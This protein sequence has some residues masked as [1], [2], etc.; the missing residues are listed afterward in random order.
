MAYYSKTDDM[1]LMIL[2]DDD[3]QNPRKDWDN[4]G[5][6]ICF[7]KRYNLGDEH[8]F[9]EPYKFF[10]EYLYENESLD[11]II[12]FARDSL[13]VDV[14]YNRRSKGYEIYNRDSL[15]TGFYKHEFIEGALKD[16]KD[17][18]ALS[19]LEALPTKELKRLFEKNNLILPIYLY[20]HSGI[21]INTTGFGCK[22]DSGQLGYIYES[23]KSISERYEQGTLAQKIDKARES[24][25]REVSVYDW[26]LTGETY[27]YKYF[28]NGAEKDSCWGFYGYV[29]DLKEPISEFLPEKAQCLMKDLT[30]V[31]DNQTQN[32]QDE[33]E[34]EER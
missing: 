19:I 30:Y 5:T 7:H 16:I 12:N 1:M 17:D 33:F 6:M 25:I 11:N 32:L 18:L 21:T 20:D 28:E 2:Q 9:N 26:Y 8:E 29:E 23:H 22:W 14:T 34:M 15:S 3:A 27:G 10:E 31:E 24:L 13:F 4:N